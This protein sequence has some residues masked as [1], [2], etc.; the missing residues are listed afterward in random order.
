MKAVSLSV[1]AQFNGA[2]PY[3]I[4]QTGSRP[5]D[6]VLLDNMFWGADPTLQTG[7][8]GQSTIIQNVV[9]SDAVDWTRVVA[10]QLPKNTA[11]VTAALLAN[12][13]AANIAV[14]PQLTDVA[15]AL[16][17]FRRLGAMDLAINH[18]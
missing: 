1:G 15:A 16:D 13:P 18:P 6:I 3:S 8:G 2:K 14:S 12:T 17:D 4:V 10:N 11:T 9:V 5:L 7:S